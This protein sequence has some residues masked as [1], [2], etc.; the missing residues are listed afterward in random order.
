MRSRMRIWLACVG[1]AW[2]SVALAGPAEDAAARL[3][4]ATA[5]H[6]AG[7]H[8]KALELVEQGL[9]AAPKDRKLIA[10][11]EKVLF[12]RGRRLFEQRD[13][14]GALDSYE[15]YLKVAPRG[16]NRR[17]V[18][19]MVKTLGPVR[20][21]ALE[22][23]VANGPAD[24]YIDAKALGAV[25][26]AATA[27][28]KPWLPG[29]VTVTAERAG[30]EPWSGP[31]TLTAGQPA[32]L[33]ITLVEK[34][35][36]LTVRA[37]PPNAKITVGGK[38]FSGAAEL[39]AGRYEVIVSLDGHA[40]QRLTVTAAEGKPVEL[41]VELRPLVA[42]RVEPPGAELLLDGKPVVVRSGGLELPPG[43]HTLVVRAPGFLEHELQIPA[44]RS[45]GYKLEVELK[46]AVAT[47][48]AGDEAEAAA[49]RS[50]WTGRR[51]L[52]LVFVG[53][54]LAAGGVGVWRGLA[55]SDVED[56]G[57]IAA[58]H[59]RDSLRLQS[60][61]AYGAAGLAALVAI[62]LWF[63]G[64]PGQSGSSPSVAVTP[65]LGGGA[66]LDVAVRF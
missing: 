37:T 51:K 56:D 31:V 35:S 11:R 5:Q 9:A 22:I 28:T 1:V 59:R 21:T 8:G 39:P 25:C 15:A 2:A 62:G 47:I 13:Y 43:A 20:T 60:H 57:T 12:E 42:V 14:L 66:G 3:K 63:D 29:A 6:R 7:N 58:D 53:V 23:T 49:R 45:A 65:R 52:S 24:I 10:L 46:P 40:E 55:A 27:C 54:G 26:P 18:E 50:R 17:N 30:F 34:P 61:L 32:Q 48:D 64:A 16:E 44:D 41:P 19:K 38:P 33:A 36:R 4:E